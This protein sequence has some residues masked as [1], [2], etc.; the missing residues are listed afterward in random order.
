MSATKRYYEEL[1]QTLTD[2]QLK[3]HGYSDEEIQFF[4]KCFGPFED[5]E[6]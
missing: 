3:E 6:Y 4:R 1:A 2:E 5:D